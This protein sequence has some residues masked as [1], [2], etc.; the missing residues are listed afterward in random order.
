VPDGRT[1]TWAEHAVTGHCL[2]GYSINQAP[3][4][5]LSHS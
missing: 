2:M 4:L 3:R 5:Y 1:N